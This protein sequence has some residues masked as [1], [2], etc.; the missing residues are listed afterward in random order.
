MKTMA[1]AAFSAPI[2]YFAYNFMTFSLFF[3][4]KSNLFYFFFLLLQNESGKS[5]RFSRAIR[6]EQVNNKKR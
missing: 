5:F 1:A 6:N 2:C 3:F 4:I